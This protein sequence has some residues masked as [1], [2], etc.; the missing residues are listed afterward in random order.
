MSVNVQVVGRLG[1]DSEVKTGKNGQFVT[2]SLATD[3]FKGGKNETAWLNVA[4]Y[5]EKGLKMAQYLKK[6]SMINVTGVETVG[7]FTNRNGEAQ[8]SR[9]IRAFNIDFVNS[10]QSGTTQSSDS[11]TATKEATDV[12]CGKLVKSKV[13]TPTP[14]QVSQ[15]SADEDLPF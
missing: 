10:G 6:G 2:F 12:S 7:I 11:T 1:N 9:D 4:Y 5:D 15:K 3:E 13:A 14:T 8:V